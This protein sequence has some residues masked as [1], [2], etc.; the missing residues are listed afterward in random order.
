MSRYL[1]HFVLPYL[2]ALPTTANDTRIGQPI[3]CV[4]KF[5]FVGLDYPENVAE[6][7]M[8]VPYEPVLLKNI[9]KCILFKVQA[10]NKNPLCLVVQ[11]VFYW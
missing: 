4:D 3:A 2:R 5:I 10:I 6:S 7:G 11:R 9:T 1:I 8:E